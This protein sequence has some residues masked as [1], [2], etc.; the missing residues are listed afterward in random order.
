MKCV[1]LIFPHQLFWPPIV[2]D[3]SIPIYLIEEHLFFREV[4]FHKQKIIFHRAS[5][6][7]Y[8]QRLSNEGFVVKYIESD[9]SQSDIR[10]LIENLK[11]QD[12]KSL[13]FYD[14]VDDW[15]SCRIVKTAKAA[16][17]EL[18]IQETPAFIN[19][20]TINQDYLKQGKRFFQNDFYIHQRKR[21][22]VLMEPNGTPVGGKWN[23]D[24]DNRE[25]FPKDAVLP[26]VKKP[27]RPIFINEALKYVQINFSEN[28]GE[29]EQFNYPITHEDAETWFEDFLENRLFDFGRFEDAMVNSDSTLFH[30]LLSPLLNVGLLTPHHI[31]K[32]VQEYTQST[33]IPLNSTEGFTRQIIGWRE[34]IRLVYEEKGRFQRTNNHYGF[35]RPLPKSFYCGETGILPFD[36]VVQK[37]NRTAYCHHIERL[38]ILGNFMLL[39]EI[40]PD[41]VYRWFTELFIDSY[42]WV[43]VPNVYGM[44][45]YSDGGLMCTKPYVSGSNYILKM[46]YFPKGD[47]CRIWDGLFWRFMHVHRDELSKNV[48]L[49]ML[50]STFDKMSSDKREAHINAAEGFLASLN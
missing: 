1:S 31:I 21:L 4:R 22:E 29:L 18:Q 50:I 43:M 3:K 15:L 38:M 20:S 2:S 36:R 24:H 16:K 26:Y 5:M 19:S 28:P 13:V 33:K 25:K 23:F 37:I 17:M 10:S 39:C 44:S 11:N 14:P 30:S 35:N 45:Q 12:V 49:A 32:R 46:S 27:S 34:Y 7:A 42:D 8:C 47:W 9:Q 48:R 6:K 41:D 40:R